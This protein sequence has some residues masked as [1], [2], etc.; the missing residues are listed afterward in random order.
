[1]KTLKITLVLVCMLMIM[2]IISKAQNKI[3]LVHQDNVRPSMIGEY[4][5]ISKEFR[6]AC[7]QYQPQTSW[8][9]SMTSDFKFLFVTPMEKFED[10]AKRPF[11]DMAKQMGDK[12]GDMFDRFDACYDSH[13]DYVVILDE[14]LTYMPNGI[15]QVQEGM[16]YRNYIYIY[17]TPEN[18]KK[19]KEGMKAIKEMFSSKGSN[20]HYRV[21]RSGFGTSE[22]YYLVTLSSK[23][24]IDSAKRSKTNDDL[25]GPER[26][27]TFDKVMKYATRME[28]YK[29][30]MRPKLAYSPK[31]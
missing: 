1:M 18:R 2:P 16:D 26:F 9:T 25:L 14:E 11:T 24:E 6:D 29:G 20:S 22:S 27:E 5:K 10:I 13:T 28:E 21:Y 8:I 4:E 3:Y 17:Y 19:I 15:K 31:K 23:D 7:E 12:F 30:R